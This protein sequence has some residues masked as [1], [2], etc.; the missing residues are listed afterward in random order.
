MKVEK[1]LPLLCSLPNSISFQNLIPL[2]LTAISK[3][4]LLTSLTLIYSIIADMVTLA[5]FEDWVIKTFVIISYY[6]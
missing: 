6:C 5:E 3:M 1:F 2:C 4:C